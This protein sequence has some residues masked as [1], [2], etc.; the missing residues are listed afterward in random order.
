[1]CDAEAGVDRPTYYHAV[2]MRSVGEVSVTLIDMWDGSTHWVMTHQRCR[3]WLHE[4]EDWLA[5]R[6]AERGD[7]FA[8]ASV[9]PGVIG[10]D[11]RGPKWRASVT[12]YT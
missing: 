5:L 3:A 8:E 10:R 4:L 2:I 1:M 6:R 11:P 7:H 12:Y 9:E